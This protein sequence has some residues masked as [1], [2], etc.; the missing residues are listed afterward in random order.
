MLQTSPTLD[1]RTDTVTGWRVKLDEA[2][3]RYLTAAGLFRQ[4]VEENCQSPATGRTSL[5]EAR[6][7]EAAALTEYRRV[8][9]IFAALTLEGK[10]PVERLR[11]GQL[12]SIIDDDESVRDSVECCLHSFGYRVRLFRSAQAFLDSDALLQTDCLV[13]DVRIPGMGGL[14]LQHRLRVAGHRLPVI[15][16]SSH[17]SA[18]NRQRAALEGALHFFSKPFNPGDFVEAVRSALAIGSKTDSDIAE[19]S[20]EQSPKSDLSRRSA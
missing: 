1:F 3:T 18:R 20:D 17:D 19:L 7:A 10:M 15:F 12:V 6:E 8:L 16:I 13:L 4:L 5:T 2:Q 11:T 9:G 14:E